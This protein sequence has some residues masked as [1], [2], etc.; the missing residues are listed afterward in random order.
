[1]IVSTVARHQK[2]AAMPFPEQS[3]FV[4]PDEKPTPEQVAIFRQ[5]TPERRLSLAEKLYWTAR[6]LK[7]AWLHAR[8]PEW[9]EQEIAQEVTR[10]FLHAR[11]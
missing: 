9:T 4:L 10:L 1:V 2:L 8:H 7:A 3:S 6:E 5:M 11:T